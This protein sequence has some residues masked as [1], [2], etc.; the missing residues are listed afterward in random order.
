MEMQ[1]YV[2]RPH[3]VSGF[4]RT[5]VIDPARTT[6]ARFNQ[7]Q[8]LRAIAGPELDD[9]REPGRRGRVSKNGGRMSTE[10]TELRTSDAVPWQLADGIKES[11]PERIVQ[12]P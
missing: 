5:V 4:S 10:Q 9:A 11:G 7:R 8:Q 2:E 6:T 1:R 12:I 3:V